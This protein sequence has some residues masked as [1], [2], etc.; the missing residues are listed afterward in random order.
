MANTTTEIATGPA[1][2]RILPVG[3]TAF[4]VE[5][6]E[7]VDAALNRQVIAL[8]QALAETPIPGVIECVPTYR[9]LL[10]FY[11]HCSVAP[12]TLEVKLLEMAQATR[13]ENVVET[14]RLVEV[15]VH[16]GGD[17]GPDLEAVAAHCRLTPDEVVALH[18]GAA[19]QVAMLGFAPGFAYLLGLPRALAMPRL[20]SP[21]LRVT[22]GSVGIAGDQTGIYAL[23]TPGGWRII[24]R[25]DLTLFDA[26]RDVPFT[27]QAGDRV[28]FV[29]VE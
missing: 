6:G 29:A 17:V 2:P 12:P 22:P 15:P 21:R 27:L 1:Y 13:G 4:T 14:R 24:G 28:R 10:V 25:T 16:Y 20:A 8:D 9:S 23:S 7:S 19:Y 3:E 11:D 18:A 26:T 5:F